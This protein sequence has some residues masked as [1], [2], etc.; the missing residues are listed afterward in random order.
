[1]KQKVAISCFLAIK[2]VISEGPPCQVLGCTFSKACYIDQSIRNWHDQD[3]TCTHRTLHS[4]ACLCHSSTREKPKIAIFI[5]ARRED[6]CLIFWSRPK[7]TASFFDLKMQNVGGNSY[8]LLSQRAKFVI[9][10]KR[11]NVFSLETQSQKLHFKNSS[12]IWII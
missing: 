2:V 4:H 12:V 7:I 1:M 8:L 10:F 11:R 6:K 5:R 3:I 9:V